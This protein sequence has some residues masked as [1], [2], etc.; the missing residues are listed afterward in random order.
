MVITSLVACLSFS[1]VGSK[2][3]KPISV[4]ADGRGFVTSEG[5]PFFW[6]GDTAWTMLTRLTIPEV[7]E[8]LA[9]RKKKGFSVI[10]L[11]LVPWDAR[12]NGNLTGQKP[13]LGDDMA[14][15]NPLYFDHVEKVLDLVERRGFYAAVVPFWLA[16]LPEPAADEMAQYRAYGR[17]L[18]SRFGKRPLIW[19]LGAD[20]WPNGWAAVIRT[21]AQ[22]LEA[23]SGRSDLLLT[24]HPAGGQSSSRF[25]HDDGWLDFNM[26]QSGHNADLLAYRLTET[27]YAK[28][29]TKPVLD[30]EA[31]YENITNA[32]VPY[33]PGVRVINDYD[34][35]RQ[36]YQSVFSGAAGH[37]Y[38]A[39]EVY[40][41]HKEGS[42]RAHWTIGIHW[43]EAL[44][45]PG[46]TQMGYLRR[47]IEGRGPSK[48][49][50]DNSLLVSPNPD[51]PNE[52]MAVIRDKD[53]RWV[54]V[55]TPTA[56]TF[57]LNTRKLLK[58]AVSGS[59][60]DPRKGMS[61]RSFNV[62]VGEDVEFV[63][64][65]GGQRVDWVLVLK[66]R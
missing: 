62:E 22:G 48:R 13:Y 21:F 20:R 63:P 33:G 41:F 32:L 58:P 12:R 56:A 47:L 59:W 35:R 15:P 43:R 40:E 61:L 57:R 52:H 53:H 10:Q 29:P 64:P 1:L 14:K 11:V 45:L 36:A 6:L 25:F 4:D 31:A 38:G 54:M 24:H 16:G 50:P 55:Y 3:L 27:D 19:L 28:Q 65:Q 9:D 8:Y 44:K 39:C 30:G 7:E 26:L 34:V 17:Y 42:G 60:F 49:V 51:N 23:S 2:G 37:T 5:K 18:G 46:S 66:S